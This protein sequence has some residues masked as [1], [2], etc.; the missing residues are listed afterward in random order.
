MMPVCVEIVLAGTGKSGGATNCVATL[1][2]RWVKGTSNPSKGEIANVLVLP[3]WVGAHTRISDMHVGYSPPPSV[4][5]EASSVKREHAR[6][7]CVN[8]V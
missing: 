1:F 6:A 8:V 4:G 2:L 5:T 3:V 7:G